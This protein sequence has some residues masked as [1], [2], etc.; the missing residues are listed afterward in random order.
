MPQQQRFPKNIAN[1]MFQAAAYFQK[2]AFDT[3]NPL[4]V[5]MADEHISLELYQQAIALSNLVAPDTEFYIQTH[6][7]ADLPQAWIYYRQVLTLCN[8]DQSASLV[9]Q[10]LSG[11]KAI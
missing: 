11:L 7:P 4:A 5:R 6:N 9:S 3:N 2:S 1:T 10:A 8:Y